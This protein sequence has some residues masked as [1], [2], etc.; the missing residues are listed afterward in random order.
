VARLFALSPEKFGRSCKDCK[1]F[2]YDERSGRQSPDRTKPGESLRRTRQM[3]D[4]PCHECGKTV[5]LEVRHYTNATDPPD[6]CYR[7]FR[8]WRTMEAVEWQVPEAADP[9]IQ[10]NA[11][12][13]NA[14]RDAQHRG[15][16]AG[17]LE[18]LGLLRR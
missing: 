14:V 5:G 8:H 9:I 1:T 3:G 18:M 10:R 11:L 17:L 16:D 4:P 13:F 7:T 6:W 2:V 15:R 12:Y